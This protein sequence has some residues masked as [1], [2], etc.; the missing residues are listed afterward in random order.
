MGAWG[1]GSFENDDAADWLAQ[2][3]KMA[4]D[5]LTKIFGHAADTTTYFEAPAASVVVAAGRGRRD[6]EWVPSQWGSTRNCEMDDESKAA[7][8]RTKSSGASSLGS[9]AEKL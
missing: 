5:D 4:P 7:D 1:S 8:S 9:S 3:N 2:L 6:S